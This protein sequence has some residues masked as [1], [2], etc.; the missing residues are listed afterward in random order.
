MSREFV[1]NI[2][3]T[4]AKKRQGRKFACNV[5]SCVDANLKD[6][7]N[8]QKEKK[9]AVRI[10]EPPIILHCNHAVVWATT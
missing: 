1:P 8:R 7:R 5:P 4:L 2:P 9:H 6:R 3:L 10:L